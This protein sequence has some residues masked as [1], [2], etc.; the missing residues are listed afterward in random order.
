[1]REGETER[2][3][4]GEKDSEKG[5]EG[6]ST[7]ASKQERQC[8]EGERNR[9]NLSKNQAFRSR[10]LDGYLGPLTVALV[11]VAASQHPSTSGKP[12]KDNTTCSRPDKILL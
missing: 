11:G 8:S 3:T 9:V 5:R 4:Q 12:K 7:K 10:Y 1:M 2:A 6:A